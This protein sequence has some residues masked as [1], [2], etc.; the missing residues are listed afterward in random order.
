MSNP[1]EKLLDALEGLL[2]ERR[3]YES[4][5]DQLEARRA[6]S[7]SHV[8][9][10]VRADYQ[11][12]LDGVTQLLRGRTADLEGSAATLRE[13]IAAIEADESR[14]RDERAET[15]LR[16]LVGEFPAEQAKESMASSDEALARLAEER[17]GHSTELARVTEILALIRPEELPPVPIEAL[18]PED[19]A[20]ASV[21]DAPSASH[22]E[23]VSDTPVDIA[24][25]PILD[26]AAELAAAADAGSRGPAT[27]ESALEPLSSPLADELA[28]LHSVVDT[29]D[30]PSHAAGRDVATQDDGRVRGEGGD[31]LPPPTLTAPRRGP[32]PQVSPR[33]ASSE[34]FGNSANRGPSLTPGSIPS[35]LKDMPTEQVKTLKCQECG[36]M[37]FPTEW[38]CERCGG[39]LA[40]M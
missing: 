26:H 7:P 29:H 12:R 28:F 34:G 38:Y 39:E 21:A 30:E 27:Q 25:E 17:G 32:T 3:R 4:W 5:I 6:A 11:S 23:R 8:V 40:A 22:G 37:N 31:L 14:Q 19:T 1:E 13:R 20:A 35:F 9:D 24:D 18:A 16:A 33:V 10:R 36:T 2:G 15:E